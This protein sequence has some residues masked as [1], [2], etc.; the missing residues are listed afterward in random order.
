MGERKHC[1]LEHAQSA[2]KRVITQLP[3]SR[4]SDRNGEYGYRPAGMAG[5]PL[6]GVENGATAT[7]PGREF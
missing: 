3:F 1:E 7:S 2:D 4:I 6:F 5:T